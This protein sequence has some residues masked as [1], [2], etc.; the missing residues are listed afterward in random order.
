[1]T[2]TQ[3]LNDM[4]TLKRYSRKPHTVKAK[5]FEKGDE[6]GFN[7][8]TKNSFFGSKLEPYI[9]TNLKDKTQTGEFDKYY[10]VFH[11]DGSKELL[12]I[13]QFHRKYECLDC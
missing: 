1:M 4:F 9:N 7:N 8:K 10:I 13:S 2:L 6:D 5:I 11:Q 3:T 12:T